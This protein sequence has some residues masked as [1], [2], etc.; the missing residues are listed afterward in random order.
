MPSNLVDDVFSSNSASIMIGHERQTMQ[1]PAV[2]ALPSSNHPALVSGTSPS[3][4]H[5]GVPSPTRKKPELTEQDFPPLGPA[6]GQRK[7]ESGSCWSDRMMAKDQSEATDGFASV[8]I[9]KITFYLFVIHQGYPRLARL[10]FSSL[11]WLLLA[12]LPSTYRLQQHPRKKDRSSISLRR[13]ISACRPTPQRP[14]AL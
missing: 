3:Q 4:A 2:V 5:K 9:N 13:L 11:H 12:C 10:R 6:K 8:R 1:T 14:L 7:A